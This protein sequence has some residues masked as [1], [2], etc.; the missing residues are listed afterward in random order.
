VFPTASMTSRGEKESNVI[1]ARLM[2][3]A[4]NYRIKS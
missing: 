2:S 4:K 3:F 1:W